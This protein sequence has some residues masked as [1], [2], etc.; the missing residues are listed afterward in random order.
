M[1]AEFITS[2]YYFVD[3]AGEPEIW[4]RRKED[5][6]I[7]RGGSKFF[8]IGL[9][10]VRHAL[11]VSAAMDTLRRNLLADPNY[12]SIASM[13]PAK[14]K[15]ARQFHAKDDPPAVRER[16]F[17]LL[18]QPGHDVRFYAVVRQ[19]RAV[20]ASIRRMEGKCGVWWTWTTSHP[21]GPT[22]R[23]TARTIR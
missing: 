1:M 11:A 16:V 21:G 17:S 6:I 15:T 19:K 20:L 3:E 12:S 9:A 7:D 18:C 4:G 2:H 8:I 22:D 10:H 13:N 23:Y 5:V 14:G